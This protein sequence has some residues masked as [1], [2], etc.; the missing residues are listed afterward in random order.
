M[1]NRII[2]A[3]GLMAII[4]GLAEGAHARTPQGA[5]ADSRTAAIEGLVQGEMAS[6]QIPGLQLAI[7]KGGEIVFTGAWGQADLGTGVPVTAR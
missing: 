5:E 1:S 3:L 6:R 4:G 7:V 2:A